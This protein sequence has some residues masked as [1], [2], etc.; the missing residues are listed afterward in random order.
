MDNRFRIPKNSSLM[1]LA[2]EL[3]KNMTPEE[4]KLWY[5]FLRTYPLKFYRQ[6]V[7]GNYICDFYCPSVRLV[8]ELDGKQHYN[9]EDAAYDRERTAFLE[10]YHITVIRY[11]DGLI[12]EQFGDV[13]KD[14]DHIVKDLIWTG[15]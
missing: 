2:K 14:I 13:C 1:T 15:D 9:E 12:R 7:I 6:K 4:K 11:Y 10:S 5:Q 8:I 3:R